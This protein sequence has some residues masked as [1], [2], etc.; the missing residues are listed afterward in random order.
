MRLKVV[1][2]MMTLFAACTQMKGV[3]SP[4]PSISPEAKAALIADIDCKDA[5]RQIEIL[6]SQRASAGQQ[7]R[8]GVR[9]VMPLAA[10]AGIVTGDYGDRLAV[11]TGRHNENVA[12][13]I[14]EI[15][16]ACGL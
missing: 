15:R 4:A 12:R 14:E 3:S 7:T 13:K 10:A 11:A 6:E 16:S 9:S 5:S 8:A 2:L 1:C